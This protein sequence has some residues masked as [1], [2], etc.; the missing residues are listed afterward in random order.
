MS[1]GLVTK[2]VIKATDTN[3]NVFDKSND[4]RKTKFTDDRFN[5]AIL[6]NMSDGRANVP[7]NLFKPI[8]AA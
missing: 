6:T 5:T 4:P 1:D 3:T 2:T 8:P 7:T